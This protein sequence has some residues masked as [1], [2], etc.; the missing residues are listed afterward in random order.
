M[1]VA[2]L[3]RVFER[4]AQNEFQ[5]AYARRI[6]TL[7]FDP[8]AGYLKGFVDLVFEWNGRFYLVDYKSNH[9]GPQPTHYDAAALEVPMSEHHYV[10][11]Y[12]LY[13]VALDRYLAL[14]LK[15]YDYER[16]FGGVYYLFLRG[17]D[18]DH[19]VGRGIFHDCPTRELIESLT[20]SLAPKPEVNA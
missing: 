20:D 9:L 8:L 16:H 11:Q 3:S 10:L 1:S 5:R 19:P 13:V 14:R 4:H 7:R 15:D 17:M 18:P 12:H 2:E 6:A